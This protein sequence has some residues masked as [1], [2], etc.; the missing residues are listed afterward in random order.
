MSCLENCLISTY[1]L[2]FSTRVQK[3]K[4]WG[5]TPS[6]T[7]RKTLFLQ[8][9]YKILFCSCNSHVLLI[10]KISNWY[11][12]LNTSKF[13]WR[14]SRAYSLSKSFAC[15]GGLNPWHGAPFNVPSDGHDYIRMFSKGFYYE[16]NSNMR[17]NCVHWKCIKQKLEGGG[18]MKF[19]KNCILCI[20]NHKLKRN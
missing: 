20:V 10:L 11:F 16:H 14:S 13:P 12:E 8:K 4:N 3:K 9:C 19:E 5:D 1:L 7:L 15:Q 6:A 18:F 2:L 17:A